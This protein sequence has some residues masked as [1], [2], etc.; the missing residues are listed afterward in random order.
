MYEVTLDTF[1]TLDDIL[2][3]L[4]AARDRCPGFTDFR[5]Q[6]GRSAEFE[7]FPRLPARAQLT[8]LRFGKDFSLGGRLGAAHRTAPALAQVLRQGEPIGAA[9]VFGLTCWF[10]EATSRQ[11][12]DACDDLR[13]AIRRG[14]PYFRYQ[15]NAS[16]V[17]LDDGYRAQFLRRLIRVARLPLALEERGGHSFLRH[18]AGG[19]LWLSKVRGPEDEDP[20]GFRCELPGTSAED[21]VARLEAGLQVSAGRRFLYEWEAYQFLDEEHRPDPAVSERLYDLVLAAG[22]PA[23]AYDLRADFD[24]LAPEGLEAIRR[25][26]GPATTVASDCFAFHL[27]GGNRVSVRVVTSAAGHRLRFVLGS[28][29]DPEL[30]A[31]LARLG[32]RL[33][34]V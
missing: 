13:V 14:K 29:N 8:G 26:C 34:G 1:L 12:A 15:A 32:L 10:E 23:S 25:L 22:L 16:R 24:L 28:R 11:P 31:A 33:P 30:R 6:P 9:G 17:D 2:R 19:D 21:L 18:T 20:S 27:P 3:V 4:Q 7:G 5:P